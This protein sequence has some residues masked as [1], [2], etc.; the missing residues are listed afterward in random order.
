MKTKDSYQDEYNK[1]FNKK[2]DQYYKNQK[3]KLE[4][5]PIVNKKIS[6]V[7]YIDKVKENSKS[8]KSKSTI[9]IF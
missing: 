8:Q 3:N 4:N 9:L 1:Y 6:A 5:L 7:D 2:S